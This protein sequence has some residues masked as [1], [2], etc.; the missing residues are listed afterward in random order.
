MNINKEKW[1]NK[2]HKDL[3]NILRNLVPLIRFLDISSDDFYDKVH[4]YERIIPHHI[5]DEI[6]AYYL[7]GIISKETILSSRIMD[8]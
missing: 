5:Y 7:K 3:E 6:M 1:T 4:P 8:N 2:N